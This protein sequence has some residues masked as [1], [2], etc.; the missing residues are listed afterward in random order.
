MT[1]LAY[2]LLTM[3]FFAAVALVARRAAGGEPAPHNPSADRVGRR[4]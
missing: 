2:I 1:D 4:K 3:V